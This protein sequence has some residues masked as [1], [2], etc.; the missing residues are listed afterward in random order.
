MPSSVPI[1]V[2]RSL[3]GDLYA[4]SVM[5]DMQNRTGVVRLI[6]DELGIVLRAERSAEAWRDTLEILRACAAVRSG[7]SALRSALEL[8]T[9]GEAATATFAA[10]CTSVT[11]LSPEMLGAGPRGRLL[12]LLD[13]TPAPED[14]AGLF[15]ESTAPLCVAPQRPDS[16]RAMVR[17]LESRTSS[18]PLFAFVE[19]VAASSDD[20][21]ARRLR[22]WVDDNVDAVDPR[23]VPEL[24]ELRVRLA[25]NPVVLGTRTHVFVRLKPDELD[26]GHYNVRAWLLP[27]GRNAA[28]NHSPDGPLTMSGISDW[29]NGVLTDHAGALTGGRRPVIE[30]FVDP[31]AM[32]E[33]VDMWRGLDDVPLGARFPVVV[34]PDE[35]PGH[36]VGPWQARWNGMAERLDSPLEPMTRWISAEG[37]ADEI[38]EDTTCVLIAEEFV[39]PDE[40][41]LRRLVELGVPVALW[42]RG[43]HDPGTRRKAISSVVRGRE[44]SGLPDSIRAFRANGWESDRP[45]DVRREYV[46]YWD[47]PTRL[48]PE[49]YDLTVPTVATLGDR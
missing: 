21:D 13:G 49:Q 1:D 19:R 47:D 37:V 33:P 12:E 36:T 29:L 27:D 17:E 3:A 43:G 26:D 5:A 30:F 40:I 4:V 2:L 24:R 35:R 23:R 28:T 15:I 31:A 16:F 45:D 41:L 32:N 14:L 34:R 39:P 22:D 18:F 11:G 46:L 38:G 44:L 25:D 6:E 9:P 7:L 20:G 42:I 10:R 8:L 48:P